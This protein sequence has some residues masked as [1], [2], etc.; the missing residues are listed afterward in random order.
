MWELLTSPVHLPSPILFGACGEGLCHNSF[1][2]L[3][4]AS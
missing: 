1:K 4:M 3:R 2:I